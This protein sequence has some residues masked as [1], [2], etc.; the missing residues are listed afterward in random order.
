MPMVRRN[1]GHRV[2]VIAADHVAKIDVRVAP[3]VIAGAFLLGVERFDRLLRRLAAEELIIVLISVAASIDVAHGDDL[4]RRQ[5][6]K[7]IQ[8]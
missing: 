5:I 6:Q 4:A 3:L 8:N 2:D 1:H 7:L